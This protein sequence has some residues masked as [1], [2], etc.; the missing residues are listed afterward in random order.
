MQKNQYQVG[1]FGKLPV[2]ADYISFNANIPEIQMFHDW[3]QEGL[4][5]CKEQFATWPNEFYR[6]PRYACFWQSAGRLMVGTLGASEDRSGRKYPFIV[7][8][9]I[10]SSGASPA[11]PFKFARFLSDA[12]ALATGGWVG[13]DLQALNHW[14][15]NY[16]FPLLP[17]NPTV[18]VLSDSAGAAIDQIV[19]SLGSP[20]KYLLFSNTLEI[21]KFIKQ[22]TGQPWNVGLRFPLSDQGDRWRVEVSIWLNLLLCYLGGSSELCCFWNCEAHYYQPYLFVFLNRPTP[23]QLR[24]LV[25]PNLEGKAIYHLDKVRLDRINEVIQ[26]MNPALKQLLDMPAL[27][28]GEFMQRF[29][30]LR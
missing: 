27:S 29:G 24:F 11:I 7:F 1:F 12:Y 16:E 22:R 5:L 28:W 23:G 3:I 30:A 21:F 14:A 4:F 20:L 2:F 26:Q 13:K 18:S 17:E 25:Q 19:G 8:I 9:R 6:M 10:D 15:E